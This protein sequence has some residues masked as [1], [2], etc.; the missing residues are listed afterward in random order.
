MLNS[1]YPNFTT[2]VDQP[3]DYE[4]N[5]LS[6]GQKRQLTVSSREFFYVLFG[7]AILLEEANRIQQQGLTKSCTTL[8]WGRTTTK[9]QNYTLSEGE[10]ED[11]TSNDVEI[12]KKKSYV[13]PLTSKWVTHDSIDSNVSSQ[14]DFSV[15]LHADDPPVYFTWSIDSPTDVGGTLQIEL[16]LE[17]V[18]N[19]NFLIKIYS[20]NIALTL[21]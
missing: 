16:K 12:L 11:I 21:I 4:M 10:V 6:D 13:Q 20:F 2:W 5:F 9:M 7:A 1:T 19:T 8:I 14:V 3:Y 18:I 17:K 15:T